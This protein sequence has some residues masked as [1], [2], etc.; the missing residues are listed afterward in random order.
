L[1]PEVISQAFPLR[2]NDFFCKRGEKNPD[3]DEY[4]ETLHA[5]ISF[6]RKRTIRSSMTLSF[7][8]CDDARVTFTNENKRKE[9]SS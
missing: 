6:L 1:Y 2:F 4:H 9:T 5:E 7:H 3:V 8:H